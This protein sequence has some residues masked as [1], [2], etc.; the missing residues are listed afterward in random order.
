M[1]K[2]NREKLNLKGLK[3]PYFFKERN[4]QNYNIIDLVYC[5]HR[6]GFEIG[7]RKRV[8]ITLIFDNQLYLCIL[9]RVHFEHP[10]KNRPLMIP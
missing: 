3:Y 5:T 1:G 4:I 7:G 6:E 8:Q 9:W 10:E 2:G